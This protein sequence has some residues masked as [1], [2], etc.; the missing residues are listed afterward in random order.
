MLGI[1]GLP[2]V[3]DALSTIMWPSMKAQEKVSKHAKVRIQRDPS[4]FEWGTEG[5]QDNS[6]SLV[7][8]LVATSGVQLSARAKRIQSEMEEL[9]KWLEQDTHNGDTDDP[10][11]MAMGSSTIVSSPTET[12]VFRDGMSSTSRENRGQQSPPAESAGFDDDFTVFVSAPAEVFG[13]S[14][15]RRT[16]TGDELEEDDGLKPLRGLG[17]Y[18]SL[19]SVSDFGEGGEDKKATDA[20]SGDDD[21]DLPT[22]KEIMETSSRIFGDKIGSRAPGDPQRIQDRE[23]DSR[24]SDAES[25]PDDMYDMSPFDLSRVLGTLQQMKEE[26]S[27]IENEDERRRAAARV[28]LGLVYGLETEGD[29][30]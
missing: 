12:S 24:S 3:L 5:A 6:S 9:T 20:V 29:L 10:W 13:E 4:L 14:P 30:E 23:V 21:E 16:L 2:R 25:E 8:D 19:G 15:D 7:D 1:P 18:N 11:S 28:A 26:I 17:S 22:Q 27:E